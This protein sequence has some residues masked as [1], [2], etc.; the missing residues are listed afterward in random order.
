MKGAAWSVLI[1]FLAIS[2]S[3]LAQFGGNGEFQV[4]TY[5]TTDQG[6]PAVAADAAGNFV[7]VWKSCFDQD[8]DLC[9]VFGQRYSRTGTVVGTEFRVNTPAL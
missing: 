1:L 6:G 3:A 8:G 5:T 9:G 4:N 2:T 7:V